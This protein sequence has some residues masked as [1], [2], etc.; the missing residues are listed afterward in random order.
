METMS[1]TFDTK[2]DAMPDNIF[3]FPRTKFIHSVGV[4]GRCKFVSNGEHQYTGIFEGADHGLVR[5][6]SA[7][8]PT[9]ITGMA[10][11]MGLK[12][13]RDGVMSSDLVAMYSGELEKGTV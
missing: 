10:P 3:G 11:G 13:L 2:S 5:L 4:V 12:F 8:A 7:I 9:N 6:S 1:P